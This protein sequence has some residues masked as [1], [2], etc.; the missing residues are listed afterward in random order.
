M[1]YSTI[2]R[3]KLFRSGAVSIEDL[4]ITDGSTGDV[5]TTNGSGVFSFTTPFSGAYSSLTGT[6]TNVSTFTNDS[7]YITDYTVT[8]ADVTAHQAALSITESQ[9]SDL[10][11]YLTEVALAD[12][13]D[14]TTTG[15]SEGDVLVQ[16]ADGSF[17]VQ[18]I[19]FGSWT[20]TEQPDGSL[21]FST[22]GEIKMSI[23]TDGTVAGATFDAGGA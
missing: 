3:A 2:D 13:T 4:N 8:E 21:A 10:Q 22:G 16:Q 14:V 18:E 19:T 9:I 6:P 12:V 23:A 15:G 1:T 7:G 20:I 17:A 5:L 11:A